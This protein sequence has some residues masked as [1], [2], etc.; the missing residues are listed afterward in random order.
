MS[1]RTPRMTAQRM[2]SLASSTFLTAQTQTPERLQELIEELTN[3]KG[4]LEVRLAAMQAALDQRRAG[5]PSEMEGQ[6]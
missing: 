2:A 6:G 4:A 1:E 5:I 3:Q